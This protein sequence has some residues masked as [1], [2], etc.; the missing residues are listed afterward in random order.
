M[1]IM[2]IDFNNIPAELRTTPNWVGFRVKAKPD[3]SGYTK[4]PVRVK[5][6]YGA[7]STK[8]ESWT[9]FDKAAAALRNG[10]HGINAIGF[11]FDGGGICGIDIDHCVGEDGGLSD[12]AKE[13]LKVVPSYTEYSPS[14]TGLHI[15]ARCGKPLGGAGINKPEIEMYESGRFFTV[16]GNRYSD[17]SSEI[18]DCT[19]AV[20]GI[21]NKYKAAASVQNLPTPKADK[22][23]GAMALSDGE[24]L[25]K[26]RRSKGGAKFDALW[27]GDFSGYKSQ[28][29]ADLALCNL[30]AFWTADDAAR[31][32]RLFQS[33]GLYRPKWNEKHGAETYG[34]KT[35][36]QVLA[37][38]HEVYKPPETAQK[39]EKRVQRGEP[40]IA[41]V[42]NA[43]H[44][45]QTD[46]KSKRLTNFIIKPELKLTTEEE[47]LYSVTLIGTDGR[48]TG[49]QLRTGDLVSAQGFKKKLNERD[50]GWVFLA[51]DRELELIKEHLNGKPCPQSVGFKG[52]GLLRL[53]T[54][55]DPNR[56]VYAGERAT[57]DGNGCG[58]IGA[59]SIS[60]ENP[61]RSDIEF[62][63]EIS[64]FELEQAGHALLEYNELPKTV[65]VLCF[66]ATALAKPKLT[67]RG[68]KFPHLV[69]VGESGSGKS[70]TTEKVI[71]SF[72]G[73]KSFVGASKITG[74]SFLTAAGASNNI[75]LIIDEYKPSTMREA[76][77]ENIH[78][79]LRDLYDGH[80][81]ERGRADMTVKKYKLTAPL[82]LC[83]EESPS[84]PALKERSI[85][86]LY[87]KQ[88]IAKRY[89]A[90]AAIERPQMQASIRQ[91]GKAVLLTALR[92]STSALR[93][94]FDNTHNKTDK[95]L[96]PRVRNNISALCVGAYLLEQ[97]AKRY[98]ADFKTAFGI[99][100]KDVLPAVTEAVK[101]YTLSGGSYNKSVV[102]QAFEIFD[103]MTAELKADVHYKRV[104]ITGV[105]AI[106]FDIKRIYDKYTKFRRDHGHKGEVLDFNMFRSQL[107]KKD[108]FIKRNHA[109]QLREDDGYG[110]GKFH[111][112]K[113][114]VLS[115]KGLSACADISNILERLG[116]K[117]E[118][119]VTEQLRLGGLT[120][121]TATDANGDILPF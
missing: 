41:E 17:S 68:I 12:F 77:V 47:M 13:I 56:W 37:R 121:V 4:E 106:A 103:R 76:I 2:N 44:L 27:R 67:E 24:L 16:T 18:V 93:T 75:P 98:G 61:I 5:D 28:S 45:V 88:D 34:Q 92:E 72:F 104:E 49:M 89:E 95:S 111:T 81:G 31:I 105:V 6:G 63:D 1:A 107:E 9:T 65:S 80:E 86:L 29:E 52:I 15:L 48:K 42:D 112:V 54:E 119:P 84:E 66:M 113:C 32:D 114:Y 46:G 97:T 120:A 115:A 36:N 118:P 23:K 35:I 74:Y 21:Y 25:E 33:S 60:S 10:R 102:D 55:D 19:D 100:M 50:I 3:G 85:E 59:E 14:G 101:N 30:L 87:S 43:Y 108:Y 38:P 20:L 7:S 58:V 39:R 40:T 110:G 64:R 78:N 82:V 62:A 71:Q 51:N 73:L 22:P 109:A 83:G 8:N 116:I 96:P 69:I 26:I 70:F 90:G 91:L 57:V 53:A 117:D 99:E 79:G 94:V 11:A